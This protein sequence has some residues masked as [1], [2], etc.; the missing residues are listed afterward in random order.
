MHL[1]EPLDSTSFKQYKHFHAKAVNQQARLGGTVFD[2]ND[3]FHA[4]HDIRQQAFTPRMIRSGFTRCGIWPL[5]KTIDSNPKD[6][7]DMP[8][9]EEDIRSSPTTSYI[10]PPKTA[11]KLRK[12]IEKFQKRLDEA[13]LSPSKTRQLN[14]ILSGS[15]IQAELGA[16]FANDIEHF[17]TLNRRKSM[18]K[19]R[20]QIKAGHALSVKDA[21]RQ[22]EAR[23]VEE[24]KKEWQRREREAKKRQ[25]ESAV[26]NVE[27]DPLFS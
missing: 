8:E 10:S 7:I 23:K 16:Q 11:P 18:L 15:L 6:I 17:V 14:K 20:R 9:E 21:N 5:R 24:M 22:I 12:R 19:T 27:S 26:Q 2:K 1:L 3:F 13:D 4:L 25:E